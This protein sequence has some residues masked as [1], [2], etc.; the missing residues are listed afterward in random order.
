MNASSEDRARGV[1]RYTEGSM[2]ENRSDRVL[3]AAHSDPGPTTDT[4]A[5][6][7][8]QCRSADLLALGRVL[9]D[10]AGV[11]SAYR[12]RACATEFFLPNTERRVG[13]RDR[14]ANP[15]RR[16]GPERRVGKRDR[17]ANTE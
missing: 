2:S 9:A 17:R 3:A 12:C 10:K 14:R 11:R 4:R 6:I 16:A 8:P 1:A 15:E 5:R 13:L 7:C